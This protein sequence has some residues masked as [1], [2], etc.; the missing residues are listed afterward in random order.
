MHH[1]NIENIAAGPSGSNR[2]PYPLTSRLETPVPNG[3]NLF[4]L[5]AGAFPV[6]AYLGKK[7]STR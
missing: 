1:I 2:A 6:F 4:R 7:I 5:E 3:R